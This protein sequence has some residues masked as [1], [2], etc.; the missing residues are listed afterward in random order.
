VHFRE[1]DCVGK[2]GKTFFK[3]AKQHERPLQHISNRQYVNPSPHFFSEFGM[4]EKACDIGKTANMRETGIVRGTARDS[5]W[6]TPIVR[7]VS[8]GKE[9]IEL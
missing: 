4:I 3:I 7:F 9:G 8:P 6:I 5:E 2:I 1:I